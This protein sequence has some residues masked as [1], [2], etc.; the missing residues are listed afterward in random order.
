[1][2]N[3]KYFD[4]FKPIFYNNY[5]CLNLTQRATFLESV[6]S[7]PFVYYPYELKDGDRPDTIAND[8]YDDQFSSWLVYYANKV[9][10]PYYDWYLDDDDF[11]SLIV[12]KYG[13]IANA[14]NRVIFYRVD[15]ADDDQRLTTS[16]YDN[17]LD[18]SLKKY[19][20]GEFAPSGAVIAYK[21]LEVDWTMNTNMIL[22]LNITLDDANSTFTEGEY[23]KFRTGS[24]NVGTMEVIT[25]NSTV[26]M[27]Q[28]V[29]I[30]HE[31]FQLGGEEFDV[32]TPNVAFQVIGADSEASAT[33]DTYSIHQ[34]NISSVET[35]YWSPVSYYDYETEKN[36]SNRIIYLL[37][38]KYQFKAKEELREAMKE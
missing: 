6:Y 5:R 17:T 12:E 26:L 13:S 16:Y 19:W 15:W 21:R 11:N 23:A 14:Q 38:S 1:M 8:Y 35:T 36:M 29:N 30:E 27:V 31:S 33:I 34:R 7:N 9:I 18:D 24:S 20:T 10:D 3:K 37:D 22:K 4:N 2:A 28:H 32:L 25:S